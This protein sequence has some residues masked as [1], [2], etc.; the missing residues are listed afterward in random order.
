MSWRANASVVLAIAACGYASA[1]DLGLIAEPYLR[2][3]LCTDPVVP[4]EKDLVT[5]LLR[6]T[7]DGT[8]AGPVPARV[9]ITAGDGRA[10]QFDLQLTATEDGGLAGSVEWKAWKNGLY[11][12][13]AVLDP[14]N[15][16]EED[17]ETNNAAEL[18][19]PVVV[20]GRKPHFVWYGEVETARWTTCVTS[21]Q[22]EEQRRRLAEHGVIP[23]H[24]EYGGM[25]WNYY[26]KELAETDCEA[27]LAEIEETFYEKF[28]RE[29]PPYSRGPGID[30]CG[31][32]PGT[33]TEQR[34]IASM[35]ALA[36]ARQERPD[37]FF[38][39]WHGGGLREGL[40]QYYRMAANLVLLEAYVFRAI[41]QELK[42][43]DIY[44]AIHDR[45]GE[46]L[47]SADMITPAY[48]NDC[49]TLMALDT[50]ERPDLIDPGE[51]EAVVRFIRQ[52]F[53]EMRG[54]AWFNGGYGGYGLKRSP[55][56]D[57]LHERVLATAD[58]LCMDYWIRPCLTLLPHSVWVRGNAQEYT[59]IAAVSNIGGIDAG[60]VTV[61]IALD[62]KPLARRTV[63][64]VPAGPSRIQNRTLVTLPV[65]VQP[66]YHVFE[67]RIVDAGGAV[68]L[69]PAR[70]CARVLGE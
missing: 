47:H 1:T 67:A 61:E 60:P 21:A 66:G 64:G 16:I 54:I 13:S 33:F 31:G 27:C 11:S 24:W 59:V 48:G 63:D 56:T 62:G 34:S 43:D 40:A 32:Y 39:V 41:P 9:T 52:V 57:R 65:Q 37:R 29:L 38:A 2:G 55:E 22:D 4:A 51:L 36:R 50:S 8:V 3:G 17:D 46:L 68:V 19:L 35:K 15:A 7:V 18:T 69:D 49:Y 10:R 70:T 20:E 5:I 26:D 44:A 12:V 23:L 45:A 14:E 28:I 25:S 42:V 58:R 6:P 53:P 30:E